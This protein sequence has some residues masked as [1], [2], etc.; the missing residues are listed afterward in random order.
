MQDLRAEAERWHRLAHKRG[1]GWR[2]WR[3]EEVEDNR[4]VGKHRLLAPGEDG[5]GEGDV[6][7][8]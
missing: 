6:L 2:V 3:W 4:I 7:R 5:K 1:P 8:P